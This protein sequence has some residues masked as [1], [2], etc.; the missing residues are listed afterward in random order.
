[1]VRRG[2]MGSRTGAFTSTDA[3]AASEHEVHRV[4]KL[5]CTGAVKV[6][7][8]GGSEPKYPPQKCRQH[9]KSA[10]KLSFSWP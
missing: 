10:A 8:P 5:E 2:Q 1:M 9:H 6:R 4:S 3:P 7:K